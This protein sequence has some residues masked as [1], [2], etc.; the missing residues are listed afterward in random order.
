MNSQ[1][2][3]ILQSQD[4]SIGYDQP[5]NKKTLIEHLNLSIYEG[6]LVCLLG[7]N[8]C[9]KSTLMRTM[10]G[11]QRA[12]A[13]KT[14]IK[15]KAVKEHDFQEMSKLLS[16][17]LSDGLGVGNLTV[18]QL[19][20]F[21]RYPYNNW[22]GKMSS[23]DR[24]IIR[25]SLEQVNILHLADR[26]I[27]QLSDGEK[28]RAM[29]AKA[30]VQDTPIVLLDEPT[31][32]LD[33]SNRVEIMR[34]LRHLARETGKAILLSTHELDLALQAADVIW[35]LNEHHQMNI[36]TP[37]DLV[38]TG[39][40]EEAFHGNSFEFDLN[41][42]NFRLNHSQHNIKIHLQA[43]GITHFWTKRALEREG[44]LVTATD[45]S[46]LTV[47]YNATEKCW[48]ISRDNH[49][50]DVNSIGELIQLIRSI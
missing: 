25:R 3:I 48:K 28:Q 6:Q 46:D 47:E 19:A 11:L 14:L 9:G 31:A 5:G 18:W 32:H 16:F 37:E 13:G 38:L 26:D 41:T 44:F 15:G 7:P 4:L 49:L 21:G 17:V 43:S 34:L 30:L 33:L 50:Q 20:S 42:G 36:G 24:E 35:L 2:N 39:K 40:F 23:E 22:F 45:D 1:R 8:G 29:I 12:L 27:T 10:S